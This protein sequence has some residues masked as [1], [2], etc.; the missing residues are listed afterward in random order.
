[1]AKR[2]R[3][4]NGMG[5]VWWD[6]N[7]QRYMGQV[8]VTGPDG[9]RR[10][11]TVVATTQEE[12]HARLDHLRA[13][14]I[15]SGG[16][17]AFITVS[18]FMTYWLDDVLPL[19]G[20][21]PGTARAYA[22]H[23]R[24]Y[25]D[26]AIGRIALDALTVAHVR[27]MLIGMY[28]RGLSAGTCKLARATLRRALN[29][30]VVDQLV[31]RNVAALAEAMPGDTPRKGTLDLEQARHLIATADTA[32]E[33]PI[34]AVMLGLGLRR[35]ELLG[36]RWADITL[37]GPR[38]KLTVAGAWAVGDG[39]PYWER[40]KA[41]SERTLHLPT[42]LVERFRTQRA[43]Q[44]GQRLRAGSRWHDEGW[45]F[46]G[47]RGRPR[48]AGAV[49][50]KVTEIAKDAGLG[51]WTPHGLRHS[52]ASILI[53]VGVPLKT[54]SEMLGHSSIRM[55]ADIYGHLMEPAKADAADAMQQAIFS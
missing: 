7:R 32:G 54:I 11:K 19:T 17:R 42:E 9:R 34:I 26:P 53:A 16:T 41:G 28:R 2:R 14:V 39:T 27:Q 55:T 33:G 52:A 46:T 48:D 8:S 1:M 24:L 49:T 4:A 35:G 15:A 37:D 30:A 6:D 10:R 13:S 47:P 31:S 38:P 5:S 29:V 22:Q 45:V 43:V 44:A 40:A 3:R 36:L 50:A 51:H 12:V 18:G 25:I 23:T 20:V 21:R